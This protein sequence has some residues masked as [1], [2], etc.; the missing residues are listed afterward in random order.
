MREKVVLAVLVLAYMVTAV[1][2]YLRA[3]NFNA[4]ALF[5]FTV[6]IIALHQYFKSRRI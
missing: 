1:A 5:G 3:G 2:V 6:G 4:K